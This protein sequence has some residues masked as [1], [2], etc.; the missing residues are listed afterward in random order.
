MILYSNASAWYQ[1]SKDGILY[2]RNLQKNRKHPTNCLSFSTS[3]RSLRSDRSMGPKLHNNPQCRYSCFSVNPNNIFLSN[4]NSSLSIIKLGDSFGTLFGPRVSS[5][6]NKTAWC[7]AKTNRIVAPIDIL[8]NPDYKD[9]F[10]LGAA[11]EQTGY[12][13]LRLSLIHIW[14]CRRAI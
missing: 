14:R 7:L 5:S 12:T 8:D 2:Q 4:I 13:H 1:Q 3:L 11:L 10:E 9:H 6:K